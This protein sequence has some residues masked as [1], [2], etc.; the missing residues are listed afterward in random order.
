MMGLTD[1]GGGNRRGGEASGREE[2]IL[3]DRVASLEG[4]SGK[5]RT[6]PAWRWLVVAISLCLGG[7]AAAQGPATVR[8][9]QPNASRFPRVRLY[10]LPQGPQGQILADL[11]AERFHV[12][13]DGRPAR[14][15]SVRASAGR[16]DVCLVLD[17]SGSM[18]LDDNLGSARKAAGDF[19]GNLRADDRA[20]V[21]GFNENVSLLQPLT[22]EGWR[23]R[24]AMTGFYSA[25]GMT[26]FYDA[27]YHAVDQVALQPAANLTTAAGVRRG[28]GRADARRLVVALTDGQD[29]SSRAGLRQIV[30]F[31]RANGVSISTVALGRL[32]NVPELRRLAAETGG[33]AVVSP[34]GAQLR[35]LYDSLATDLHSEYE[36]LYETP[37]PA[38]DGTERHVSLTLSG[39]SAAPATGVY[40]AP[41]VGS[42]LVV[43]TDR[44]TAGA[45]VATG[46]RQPNPTLSFAVLAG[47]LLLAAALVGMLMLWSRRRNVPAPAAPVASAA[48]ARMPLLNITQEHTV[49]G[50]D[51]ESDLCL[52]DRSVS[53][54]HARLDADPGPPARYRLVDLGSHNGTFLNGR[55]VR[56]ATVRPGDRIRFGS[57]EFVFAGFAAEAG[58]E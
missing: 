12:E 54:R 20:A 24:K 45:P 15:L 1:L 58:G 40:Q 46:S 8:L 3:V 56:A 22:G 44:P 26:S 11:P 14:I 5:N 29:T 16:L 48:P 38:A 49:I 7:A 17:R 6:T 9:A 4:R 57:E 50:R 2:S 39:V 55:R 51:A 30:Q 18:R 21:I 41:G 10:A 33:V 36:V 34:T 32:A 52:Q 42:M 47:T 35:D 13:E 19:L 37:R 28:Q 53:R 27:L 23:L 43:V 25:A 31:A